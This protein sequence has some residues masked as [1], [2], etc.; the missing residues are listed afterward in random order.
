MVHLAHYRQPY[1]LYELI[2]TKM[3]QNALNH[4]ERLAVR[5]SSYIMEIVEILCS[6]IPTTS[7]TSYTSYMLNAINQVRNMKYIKNN[8]F[9]LAFQKA[10]HSFQKWL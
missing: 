3:E 4:N 8:L 6:Q 10:T 9:V 2:V 5:L 1:T 7:Y